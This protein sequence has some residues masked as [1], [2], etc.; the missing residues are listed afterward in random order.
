[1]VPETV[2]GWYIIGTISVNAGVW[3]IYQDGVVVNHGSGVYPVL[4]C[5]ESVVRTVNNQTID[6]V[7]TFLQPINGNLIGDVT[8]EASDCSRSVL[9]GQGLVGG[10]KLVSNVQLDV[11]HDTSLGGNLRPTACS[12][13]PGLEKGSS[14]ISGIPAD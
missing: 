1:M 9:A 12:T 4:E 2:T 5:D 8:G 3:A 13:G 11:S 14:G 7:K 10:G 6:G